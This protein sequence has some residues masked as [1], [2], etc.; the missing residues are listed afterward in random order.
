MSLTFSPMLVPVIPNKREESYTKISPCIRDKD[1]SRSLSGAIVEGVEMTPRAK[2]R[3][4]L[5]LK[6]FSPDPFSENLSLRRHFRNHPNDILPHFLRA[7][8]KEN[9]KF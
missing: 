3:H 1:F 4:V 2:F 9:R 7:H 8:G 5:S 6:F